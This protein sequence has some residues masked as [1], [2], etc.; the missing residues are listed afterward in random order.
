MCPV[1]EHGEAPN[2]HPMDDHI[3]LLTS[4]VIALDAERPDPSDG[5]AWIEF[6]EALMGLHGALVALQGLRCR[7]GVTS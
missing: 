7:Q 3:A 2:G 5:S 1:R 6:D 4:V